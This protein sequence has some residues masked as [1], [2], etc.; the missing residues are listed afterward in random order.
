MIWYN[1]FNS[2]RAYNMSTGK[3]V[4]IYTRVSTKKQTT[5]N[6]LQELQNWAARAGYSIV[7]INEDKGV[8]GSKGR[9]KR[10]QFDALLKAAVRREFEMIAVW[11]SDRLGRSMLHLIQ[12]VETIKGTCVG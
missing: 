11:S 7:N 2:I 10:P 1:I 6:Q 3:K 9:D 8:S 4:A 5:E 12:V